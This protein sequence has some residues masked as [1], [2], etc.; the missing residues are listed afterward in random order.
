MEAE[1]EKGRETN[2]SEAKETTATKRLLYKESETSS[3]KLKKSI[4]TMGPR[5]HGRF[6]PNFGSYNKQGKYWKI[7]R[8]YQGTNLDWNDLPRRIKLILRGRWIRRERY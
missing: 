8:P 2:K 7:L 4:R 3:Q 6:F 5:H 1:A